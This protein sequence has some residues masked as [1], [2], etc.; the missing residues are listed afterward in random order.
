MSVAWTSLRSLSGAADLVRAS[1]RGSERVEKVVVYGR[2]EFRHDVTRALLLLRDKRLP[3][4]DTL[5]QHVGSIIEGS[6][7]SVYAAA[8]PAFMFI[9]GSHSRQLP[10]LLAGDIAYLAC[11]CQ[12]HRTHQAE[13]PGRR[14]PRDVYF[15]SAAW[16][17]CEN[18]YRECLLALGIEKERADHIV[19][20]RRDW[21]NQ[22]R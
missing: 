21:R 2:P 4:W 13:F 9:D 5:T 11:S 19:N 6:R 10:E 1:L 22:S 14:V 8:H 3:A 20:F 7:M 12:L 15:G 18:A 16:E 17:R